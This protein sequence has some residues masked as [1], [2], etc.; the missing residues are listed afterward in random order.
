MWQVE[1]A[2]L[3]YKVFA[4]AARLDPSARGVG[5]EAKVYNDLACTIA[6]R[7]PLYFPR[8]GHYWNSVLGDLRSK[9]K[10]LS[11]AA[12]GMRVCVCGGGG[13]S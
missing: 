11:A 5:G 8:P 3:V 7:C 6:M 9:T 12:R 10:V 13:G 1:Q 4:D 2:L